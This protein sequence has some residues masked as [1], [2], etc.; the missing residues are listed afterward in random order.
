VHVAGNFGNAGV[1]EVDVFLEESVGRVGVLGVLL[2]ALKHGFGAEIGEVGVV[3][4][5]V[6]EAV[7][8]ENLELGLIC[9]GDVGKVRVVVCIDVVWVCLALLKLRLGTRL[10]VESTHLFIPQMIPVRRRER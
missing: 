3:E 2:P 1:V 6:A 9:F 8:V 4:L 5:D 7:V 10:F